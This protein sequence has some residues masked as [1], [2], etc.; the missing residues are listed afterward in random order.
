M[1]SRERLKHLKVAGQFLFPRFK[2]NIPPLAT[3]QFT[4]PNTICLATVFTTILFYHNSPALYVTTT[5]A[6]Y[7]GQKASVEAGEAKTKGD[8]PRVCPEI[9]VPEQ[10]N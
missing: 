4:F 1:T 8:P 5:A 7:G 2:P 9:S 10:V 6:A 3:F